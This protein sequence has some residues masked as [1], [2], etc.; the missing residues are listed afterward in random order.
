MPI[1]RFEFLI[2]LGIFTTVPGNVNVSRA[3]RLTSFGNEMLKAASQ[4]AN[5]PSPLRCQLNRYAVRVVRLMKRYAVN[6]NSLAYLFALSG[7]TPSGA[8]HCVCYLSNYAAGQA[9]LRFVLTAC[10][11][12]K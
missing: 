6:C 2:L 1:R 10:L 7:I 12:S 5:I 8:R 11:R 9:A 4:A 3:M